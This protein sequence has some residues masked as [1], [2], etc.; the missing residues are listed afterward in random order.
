MKKPNKRNY[1]TVKSSSGSTGRGYDM[2]TKYDKSHKAIEKS[3]GDYG[4]G[5]KDISGYPR[6]KSNS[7]HY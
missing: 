1:D 7:K 2:Y 5:F 4:P 3:G 6:P